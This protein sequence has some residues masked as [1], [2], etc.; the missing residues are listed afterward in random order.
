MTSGAS[1]D[2]EQTA[3]LI[4][5]LVE[6]KIAYANSEEE[7]VAAPLVALDSQQHSG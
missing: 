5:S 2:D 1:G 6:A 4:T 7:K 3:Q